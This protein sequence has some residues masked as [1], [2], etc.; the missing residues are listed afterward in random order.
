MPRPE[1][2]VAKHT[3]LKIM[4]LSLVANVSFP[5]SAIRETTLEDV[6]RV[7]Q[8]AEPKLRTLV[9]EVLARV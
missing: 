2:L 1:V 8:E 6:I 5:P 4:M 3:G 9:W 7:G